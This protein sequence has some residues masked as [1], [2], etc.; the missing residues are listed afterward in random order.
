MKTIYKQMRYDKTT[1]F[2]EHKAD[3]ILGNGPLEELASDARFCFHRL[4]DVF[5][6]DGPGDKRPCKADSVLNALIRRTKDIYGFVDDGKT[7]TVYLKNC[8]LSPSR[9]GQVSP[10]G[11][12]LCD[13]SRGWRY[14]ITRWSPGSNVRSVLTIDRFMP[15]FIRQAELISMLARIKL[16]EETSKD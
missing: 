6:K 4:L 2:I 16:A 1:A 10:V 8:E 12:M 15:E 13:R 14:E 7:Y 9:H 11:I 5:C 3:I